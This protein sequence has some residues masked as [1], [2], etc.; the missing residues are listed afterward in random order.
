MG[1][2]G[3]RSDYNV[4]QPPTYMVH[5]ISPS[6]TGLNHCC[7]RNG[8]PQINL[9]EVEILIQQETK[10]DKHENQNNCYLKTKITVICIVTL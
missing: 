1:H 5:P 3:A 7:T 9:K 6:Q 2:I 4:G 8:N 10:K